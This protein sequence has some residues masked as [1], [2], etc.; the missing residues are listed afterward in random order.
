MG[1]VGKK[2]GHIRI[3][4]LLGEGGM[5]EV[6]VGF[7][8]KLRRRV[9]VKA[10]RSEYRLRRETKARFLREARMLSKLDHP[11]ICRIYDYV[12]DEERDFLVLE[13]I[14]GRNL[15]RAL[16]RGLGRTAKMRVAEQMFRVLAD[17]H[18]KGVVHRDI[19]P[20]NVMLTPEGD[21]KVLDFGLARPVP[22][23]IPPIPAT[24]SPAG[25]VA[26][27]GGDP[28]GDDTTPVGRTSLPAFEA[29]AEARTVG[30][31]ILGTPLFMSPEQ[32]RGET[33]TPASDMYSCGL[34][35]QWLFTEESHYG[36]APHRLAILEWA[37]AGETRPVRGLDPD[38]TRLINRLKSVAPTTRP[39]AAEAGERLRWIL[40]KPARRIRN[41]AAVAVVAVVILAGLR[42]TSDLRRERAAALAAR[43]E[44]TEV[45][46][47]LVSL[48][49]VS[50]PGEAR[51]NTVTAREILDAGADRVGKELGDR[52]LTRA[53][54]L[55]TIGTVYR[56]LGL[57]EEAERLLV[58]GLEAR[59][60]QLTGDD[61]LVAESLDH[62][63]V[64]YETQG[65][66]DEAESL[67]SR[68]LRI[69]ESQRDPNR[70]E[71][72]ATLHGLAR[73]FHKHGAFSV[74]ESLYARALTIRETVLGPEHPDVAESLRDFG[75][76]LYM[77]GEYEE[78]ERL[79]RRSL[80]IRERVLA[81]DHPDIGR[82]LNSL[83]ALY[84]VQ[85]DLDAAEPLYRRAH[86]VREKS[87]GPDHPEVATGLFN[88]ASV[89]F[90]RGDLEAAES[91]YLRAL[92]IRERSLGPEHPDVAAS[93]NGL[94]IL[95]TQQ[96]RHREAEACYERAIGVQERAL[97]PDDV[98]V[99]A[100][101]HNLAYLLQEQAR[102]SEAFELLERALE[103]RRAKLGPDH[104]DVATTL[105]NLGHAASALGRIERMKSSFERA[106]EI[107]ERLLEPGDPQI[108]TTR[109]SYV[110]ALREHGL[111]EEASAIAAPH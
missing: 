12:E 41:L 78:A 20:E 88:L 15:R 87:L 83:A 26:P 28:S 96:E 44:V 77:Q 99:A 25:D 92:D 43:D 8:E 101:L 90:G 53:R 62:L 70:S 105:V 14:P 3:G 5:G 100:S 27:S 33:A 111:E 39:S 69:R 73:S 49:E 59:R 7:D 58:D 23:E 102:H 94:A 85:G 65:R 84:Y 95:Y 19:K 13:L 30:G 18:E 103:I 60:G 4:D 24:E 66:Y 1:L 47:F 10:I 72:A 82:S 48:F 108:A 98:E 64:L 93:L 56:N 52:P 9:A 40:G 51:G 6:Y 109:E 54:L 97:G 71:I 17:A 74:A 50:D 35:L 11:N 22:Q 61:P 37:R 68:A 36:E 42:Y 91:L 38:L 63:G 104:P 81:P 80:A 57:Y 31:Q 86:R 107:R 110:E 32:A 29:D 45:V 76:L 89:E 34:L 55:D 79:F 106:I 75:V 21:V 67:L 2:I 16:K 46:D